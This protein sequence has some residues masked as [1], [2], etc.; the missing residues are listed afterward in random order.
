NANSLRL[1]AE[2]FKANNWNTI[3]TPLTDSAD[4]Y[5]L[6][7]S[8]DF[9]AAALFARYDRVKTSKDL[10]PGLKYTYYNVGVAFPITKGVRVAVAYKNDELKDDSK[11]DTKTREISAWGEVKW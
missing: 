10:D 1:G 9:G 3:T 5:S 4:G 2:Y 7:E 6:W 8:Y 11:I